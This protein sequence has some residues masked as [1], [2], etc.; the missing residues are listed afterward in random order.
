MKPPALLSLF[1]AVV[2]L[3]LFVPAVSAQDDKPASVSA[4]QKPFYDS[5]QAF[6][7]AYAKGDAA[8][9][10]EM[11]TEDAE[12]YDEFGEQTVGREAI[13][14]LFQ[15]VFDNSPEASIQEI[16]I[17]RIRAISGSVTLEEGHVISADGP[18]RP[19]FRSKYVALHTKGSDGQWRINTLKDYPRESVSRQDHLSE[20]AWLIGDWVNEDDDAVVHTSYGWADNG[21]YILGEFSIRTFDGRE[22]SGSSRIGWDPAR[23]KIRSWTFDAD[24]G[25]FTGLWT[26]DG[27]NWVRTTAGVTAGGQTVTA[28]TVFELVD[29]EMIRWQYR[30]LIVGEEIRG[31][32]PVVTMVK[33][34]PGPASGEDDGSNNK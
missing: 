26:R 27:G 11:F 8:A 10:A 23:K 29:A 34:P 28:T 22:L 15:D 12:I 9:I 20:L 25:H 31:D 1:P 7:D 33:R 19:R 24:G 30:S 13:E 16:Q 18:D 2:C 3:A 6:V 17:D 5:A 4:E 32:S 14:A 21:N